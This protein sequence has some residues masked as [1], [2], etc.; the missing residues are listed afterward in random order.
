[1]TIKEVV[2]VFTD[3]VPYRRPVKYAREGNTWYLYT[4]NMA[5][6]G[7]HLN[8]IENGYYSVEGNK[9]LPAYPVDMPDG[10]EFISVPFNLRAPSTPEP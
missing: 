3:K 9:V 1:M 2:K 10:I 5:N 7:T 4:E 6:G 8:V